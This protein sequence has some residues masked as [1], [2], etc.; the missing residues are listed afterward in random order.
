MSKT[1]DF[2]IIVIG[3]GAAGEGAAY[4]GA[5]LGGKVAIIERELVGGECSFWAC[6]PSKTLLHSAAK[7]HS[8]RSA[9]ERR[10]WMISRE[11]IDYPSDETHVQRLEEQG[12]AVVRGSARITGKGSV[13]VVA[14]GQVP[15]SLTCTNIVVAAGSVPF[16]PA[17]PGLLEA[18]Y[19]T[20]REATS[21][22]DL[23]SS[24]VIMG[25]GPMGVETAQLYTRFGV[26]VVL[27]DGND[28]ILPR[29]HPASSLAVSGRLVEE[30]VSM[31]LGVR[32]VAVKQGGAGRIVELSDGTQV[33]GSELVL[34]VGR[35]GADL[36]QLGVEEAGVILGKGGIPS[37][38]DQMRIGPGVFVAGDASG[39]L[40]F[41]HLAD[42]EGRVAAK[43]AMGKPAKADHASV[44]KATYTDPETG[45]VGVM[46]PEALAGGMDAFEVTQEFAMTSKGMTVE[47]AVGHM[48]AVVDRSNGLLVGAFAACLGAS[49]FIHEAVLAIKYQLPV[50]AIGDT[51][52]AFPTAARGF[53]NMMLEAEKQL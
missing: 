53:A 29:D 20:N 40:Q 18:G 36:R 12:V 28:R 48:S 10:D 47:G 37:P 34:A 21:A 2:D 23:P 50:S 22:R 8:W 45:A 35:R 32:V 51:I 26:S 42:Y 3:A 25:A 19:W 31:K 14:D 6:M 13:E 46:L 52:H 41:T 33:E 38:D 9:S 5:E 49:E 15:R 17:V 44:P 24:L 16:V 11:G 43:A 27:I 39:G 7:H 1:L 4:M 30:G